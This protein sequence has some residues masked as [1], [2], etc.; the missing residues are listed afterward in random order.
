MH[1]RGPFLV[2]GSLALLALGGATF[3]RSHAAP[4]G[5]RIIVNP[6][7]PTAS[8]DRKFLAE[9]FLKKTTRWPDGEFI[10]PVDLAPN[11]AAR[12]RFTEDALNRSVAAVKSYWQQQ[13]FAGRSVPP[14]ELNG[15]EEAVK[16]VARYPGAMGYVG[17]TGELAGVKVVS[18]R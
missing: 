16:Y 10:R 2:L 12:Q 6:A 11:A 18:V 14:A 15:E 13:I 1:L 17:A 5:Y 7:N 4:S 8:L 9:A 3:E